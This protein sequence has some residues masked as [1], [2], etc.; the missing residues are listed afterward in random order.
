MR[1]GGASSPQSKASSTTT[2]RGTNGA[3]S[4]SSRDVCRRRAGRPDDVAEDLRAQVDGARRWPGRRGRAGACAGLWRR[5][6]FGSPGPV[7]PD[8]R[9]AGPVGRRRWPRT[10]RRGSGRSVR[11][12]VPILQCGRRP[13][14]G[15]IR[16]RRPRRRTRR[17]PCRSRAASHRAA[18][19]DPACDAPRHCSECRAWRGGRRAPRCA[20]LRTSRGVVRGVLRGPRRADLDIC[21]GGPVGDPVW[22]V[23]GNYGPAHPDRPAASL[24]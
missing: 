14:T 8:S 10:R 3:L 5:P 4:R 9:S 6:S 24:V 11:C 17:S 15:T 18:G 1:R 7:R 12:G 19:A 22:R 20:P 16:R 13:R 2:P 21:P 23:W